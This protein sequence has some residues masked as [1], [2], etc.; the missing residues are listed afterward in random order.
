MANMTSETVGRANGA[1]SHEFRNRAE[2][3]IDKFSHQAGEKIGSIASQLSDSATEYAETG[4][5]YVK[6]NPLQSVAIAAAAG[7]VVGG[8]LSLSMRSRR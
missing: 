7:A 1:S 5:K 4:R 8:L 3:A 2:N 6:E